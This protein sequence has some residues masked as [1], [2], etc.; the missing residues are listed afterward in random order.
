[1][2]GDPLPGV[3]PVGVV[4]PEARSVEGLM[5]LAILGVPREVLHCPVAM[6]KPA[7]TIVPASK[8][9]PAHTVHKESVHVY[10]LN[11]KH[12]FEINRSFGASSSV[13]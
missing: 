2:F 7:L 1:M 5:H 6:E 9:V 3:A 8:F 11:H 4:P 12:Y 13:K 10:H